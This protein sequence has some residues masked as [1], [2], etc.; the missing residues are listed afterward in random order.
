MRKRD[1]AGAP[2]PKTAEHHP[3][4]PLARLL[5]YLADCE[6]A[7]RREEEAREEQERRAKAPA[8]DRGK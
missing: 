1:R 6:R 2:D 5:L 7:K 8:P 4:D 3:F